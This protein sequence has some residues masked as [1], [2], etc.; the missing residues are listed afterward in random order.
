VFWKLMMK[1]TDEMHRRRGCAI[2]EHLDFLVNHCQLRLGVP[3]RLQGPSF[4]G[5]QHSA[6]ISPIVPPYHT[7]LYGIRALYLNLT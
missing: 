1:E 5:L 2:M 4:S 6:I 7:A 3:M